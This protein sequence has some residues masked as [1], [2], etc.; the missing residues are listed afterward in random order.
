MYCCRIIRVYFVQDLQ[1]RTCHVKALILCTADSVLSELGE[2]QLRH[3]AGDMLEGY[4]SGVASPLE[5]S[6]SFR[7]RR[8]RCVCCGIVSNDYERLGC[9]AS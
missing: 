8:R 9:G 7:C 3:L 4:G 1:Y 2:G 5:L 6:R